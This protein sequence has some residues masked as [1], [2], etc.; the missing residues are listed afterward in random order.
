MLNDDKP[1]KK[2][3]RVLKINK[4]DKKK[5]LVKLAEQADKWFM[6][7]KF[8]WGYLLDL[9]YPA[10]Y[11]TVDGEIAGFILYAENHYEIGTNMKM[12]YVKPKFRRMGLLSK[13]VDK[14]PGKRIYWGV[15]INNINAIRAYW[16][17]GAYI[18]QNSEDELVG[19]IYR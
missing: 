17:I 8:S 12:V 15:H 5:E 13:M 2:K 19:V 6:D 10:I 18:S 4:L 11:C 3:I 9:Y 7:N 16:K 1:L 14:V